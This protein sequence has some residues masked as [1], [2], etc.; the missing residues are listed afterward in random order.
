M[1][2]GSGW[3]LMDRLLEVLGSWPSAVRGPAVDFDL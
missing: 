2:A 3:W 1:L